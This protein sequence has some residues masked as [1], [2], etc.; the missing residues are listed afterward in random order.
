MIEYFKIINVIIGAF[1]GAGFASGQEIYL[2]FFLYGIKGL[3]GIVISLIFIVYIIYKSLFIITKNNIDNYRDFLNH[4]FNNKRLKILLNIII[5][6]FIFITFC[7][8]IAG[9]GAY[10]EQEFHIKSVLGSILLSFICA[11]I[12][13]KDI[14]GIIK[15]NQFLIPLLLFFFLVIGAL[16]ITNV[17]KINNLKSI[18]TNYFYVIY[19][20]ILY[21]SYNSILLIPV[22]IT[23]KKY[24]KNY[25][26]ELIIISIISIIVLGI[27]AF[28]IFFLLLNINFNDLNKMSMPAVCAVGVI[29]PEFRFIYGLI[30]L[31]SIFTTSISLGISL[32]NDISKNGRYNYYVVMFICFCAVLF[33][34]IGFSSLIKCLYPLFGLLGIVQFLAIFLK[35]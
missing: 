14:N 16:N 4:I 30:I 26:K 9:F 34:N 27:L 33:S 31:I 12:L 11:L 23:L 35:N 25:K 20:G 28:V 10:F 5:N 24:I 19:S 22:L 1:I 3:V 32:I 29:L 13:F 8:M 2:F 15:V 17:V 7:I 18:D 6:S 21:A